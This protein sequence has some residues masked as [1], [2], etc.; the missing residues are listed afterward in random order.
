[1]VNLTNVLVLGQFKS[2]VP[3]QLKL[4][5]RATISH[6]NFRVTSHLEVQVSA[7]PNFRVVNLPKV[8]VLGRLKVQLTN[9]FISEASPSVVPMINFLS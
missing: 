8:Q 1:M 9:R 4:K 5:A 3:G 2:I 6:L 7:Q